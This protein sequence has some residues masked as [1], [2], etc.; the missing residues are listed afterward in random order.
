MDEN[1][2]KAPSTHQVGMVL[3]TLSVSELEERIEQLQAEIER[4]KAAI[5]AR[6]NTRKAAEAAFRL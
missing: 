1:P 5:A 3:D 6:D 2:I 4:V